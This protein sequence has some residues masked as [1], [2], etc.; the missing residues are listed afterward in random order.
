MLNDTEGGV[1]HLQGFRAGLEAGLTAH[2][3]ELPEDPIGGR[4]TPPAEDSRTLSPM[5]SSG[6]IERPVSW[7]ALAGFMGTGKS[8][9]GWELS[10]ALA[11]HFVDTDKLI[12]RVVG[13]SIPEVFAQEGEGYFRACEHEVVGRVTRLEHAVIS[14]G[15][16]T[17]IQEDNRRCLLE[18]GP[19][20]VLW[21]TPETVYQRT[22]HSDRPLLR[23]EDPLERIRT[24]MDERAPV[25]Q[26]GTIHV[27]SDGR[28]SEEIVEEI[29]DRLWS[30]A[31]AQHAWTLDHVAHDHT[32]DAAGGGESRASD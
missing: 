24:L 15:G 16:G 3:R 26:Q 13:K 23:T 21:A 8:R 7:V 30:W 2:L 5:F 6:L 14:L 9:I 27:H 29:I 19:V 32:P 4:V 31:D 25:Y 17:F 12:T 18:R 22:K 1:R 28:P 11:L 10:R 20:V